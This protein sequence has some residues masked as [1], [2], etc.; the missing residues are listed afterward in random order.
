MLGAAAVALYGGTANH[1]APAAS[2]TAATAISYARQQ[3]GKPYEWGGTGPDAFDCSGLVMAAYATAGVTVPHTSQDQWATEPHVST[4]EPGDAVFFVG[5]DGTTSAPGHE[6]IVIGP[7]TMIEAYA[8]GYPVRIS[9]FGLPT[10]PP[11]DQDPV[12]YTDPTAGG[13]AA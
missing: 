12:G 4:P 7:N 3:I 8:Q 9:T 13:R 10:S 5:S 6:G 11:G 2:G 1:G